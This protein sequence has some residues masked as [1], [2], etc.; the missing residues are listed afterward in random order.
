MHKSTN[1]TR[2]GIVSV[3]TNKYFDY[4]LEMYESAASKIYSQNVT[5]HIFTNHTPEQV[6]KKLNIKQHPVVI[7]NIPDFTWPNATLLRYQVITQYKNLLNHEILMH[8]DADMLVMED[9]IESILEE[10][11]KAGIALVRHPGFYRPSGFGRVRFYLSNFKFLIRDIRMYMKLGGLGGWCMDTN[12]LSF[13]SKS[14]R[15]HYVCGATWMGERVPFL[16][17]VNELAQSVD[18]DL[19]NGVIATW[20]DESHL[21]KWAASN[22]HTI[23]DPIYCFDPTYP[24]L[25]KLPE[26]IRAV[27]KRAL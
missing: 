8:L 2:I 4:W 23:Y 13:T 5:F 16:Q 19:Q 18:T 20:H 17:M 3:A 12:S 7:H 6:F 15:K 10:D 1:A 9:F 27:D 21:N 25:E 22:S 14:L 26:F 24:Q 11:W